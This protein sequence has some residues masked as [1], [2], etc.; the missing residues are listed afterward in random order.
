MTDLDW[1]STDIVPPLLSETA[2][3]WRFGLN[4]ANQEIAALAGLLSDDEL[5]RAERFT[6]PGLRERYIAGRGILRTIL[7]HYL[8]TPPER[9]RF[10]YNHYGK[11]LLDEAGGTIKFNLSHSGDW[12][13][14]GVAGGAEIGVDIER[15]RR[16]VQCESLARHFFSPAEVAALEAVAPGE[17]REAFFAC[18]SRKEAYIKAVGRALAIPLDSFSVSLAPASRRHCSGWTMNPRPRA[19]GASRRSRRSRT[20]RPQFAWNSR[21]T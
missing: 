5:A 15:H 3:V 17:R 2:D 4:R 1:P 12:A 19:A 11:P 14:L 6:F 21:F 7:G 20:S 10:T 9:V 16:E 18:W 8:H 13:L